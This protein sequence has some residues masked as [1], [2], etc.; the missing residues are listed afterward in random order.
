[1]NRF[2]SSPSLWQKYPKDRSRTPMG[3]IRP[4]PEWHLSKVS[5]TSSK[6]LDP[7]KYLRF[8]DELTSQAYKPS[9]SYSVGRTLT[10]SPNSKCAPCNIT[11]ANEWQS[12]PCCRGKSG[13]HGGGLTQE[14]LDML[15]VFEDSPGTTNAKAKTYMLPQ[16]Y[17]ANSAQLFGH[18]Y[19]DAIS[20]T[21]RLQK[22]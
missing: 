7:M 14:E 12:L 16:P 1:M 17:S 21:R 15:C 19:S 10:A 22:L 11:C 6:C 13:I 3:S 5:Y 2:N 8:D 4:S 20:T 18:R 9:G